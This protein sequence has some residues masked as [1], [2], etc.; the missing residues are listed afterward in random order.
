[1]DK[2]IRYRNLKRP[3]FESAAIPVPVP[4]VHSSFLV[5]NA[6]SS[7]NALSQVSHNISCTSSVKIRKE[8]KRKIDPDER[9]WFLRYEPRT[10]KELVG[11]YS[12][13]KKILA[14]LADWALGGAAKS[15]KPLL[16]LQGPT[17]TGKTVAAKLYLQEKY[18]VITIAAAEV[19]DVESLR[20]TLCQ[21]VASQSPVAGRKHAILFDEADLL[22]KPDFFQMIVEF[23]TKTT[24]QGP[25]VLTL[26]DS[27]QKHMAFLVKNATIV[28]FYVVD[29][30]HILTIVGNVVGKS[31]Y[32]GT[33][34]LFHR[35]S[36][37]AHGDVRAALTSVQ[38]LLETNIPGFTNQVG[39]KNNF[40]SLFDAGKALLHWRPDI[41]ETSKLVMDPVDKKFPVEIESSLNYAKEDGTRLNAFLHTNFLEVNA[42]AFSG[43]NHSA[44]AQ[45]LSDLSV[46]AD[47]F[48][49]F[50]M[51]EK[52]GKSPVHL[53]PFVGLYGRQIPKGR[54]DYPHKTL[55]PNPKP[56][57]EEGFFLSL[58]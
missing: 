26:T 39:N 6:S 48:S 34:P 51:Q 24:L 42:S 21:A 20:K 43:K 25:I 50:D 47:I 27:H 49:L 57:P 31:T 22:M 56:K 29:A 23:A 8:S 17:G 36:N 53:L 54:L 7:I 30:K 13:K 44:D 35:V 15:F 45:F 32:T 19:D 2:P 38:F 4:A 41:A 11:L 33:I 9:P 16:V 3:H 18:E 12:Q 5:T 37:E 40:Y 55:V 14:W 58:G 10:S 46:V 1:M 52:P 28:P